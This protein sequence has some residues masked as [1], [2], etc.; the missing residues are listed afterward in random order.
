MKPKRLTLIINPISGTLSKKRVAQRVPEMLEACGFEVRTEFTTGP[1]DATRIAK[2]AAAEGAYGVI[3]CGGD[4]T[5]NEVA[6]GLINTDTALAV[7]PTGSGNGLA[8]HIGIPIDVVQA[9]KI[10][11]AAEIVD[12]DYCTANGKPFFCTF[13]MGFDAAVSHRFAAKKRRGLGSYVASAIEEYQQYDCDTY[14]IVAKDNVITDRAFIVVACNASQYGNNAFIAP[15]ASIRDG[16]LDVTIVADTNLFAQ[17][18]SGIEMIAGTLGNGGASRTFRTESVTIER[19][20]PGVAHID[21]EP[22]EMPAQIE[23]KCHHGGLKMFVNGKKGKFIPFITP[24]RMFFSDLW[25][26]AT[27][28]A[29]P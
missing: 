25:W 29:R 15:A 13:G 17:A 14:R 27:R 12:C 28:W 20:K 23:V 11:A 22:V 18:I 16:L 1:G 6:T 9:V 5:V 21:G 2:E 4:G 19:N 8:R 7:I 10:I 3:A 26:T 24:T